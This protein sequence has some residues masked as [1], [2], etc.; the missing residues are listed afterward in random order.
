MIFTPRNAPSP[1]IAARALAYFLT[2]ISFYRIENIVS[3]PS[4]ATKL[5]LCA[6]DI[7]TF[8]DG[9][10]LRHKFHKTNVSTAIPPCQRCQSFCDNLQRMILLYHPFGYARR[11]ITRCTCSSVRTQSVLQLHPFELLHSS[12]Y[13]TS[14]CRNCLTQA[15]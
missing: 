15:S 1:P 5:Y 13:H 14:F 4:F 11:P 2:V 9:T 3:I 7:S 10:Y 8:G 6:S 12:I